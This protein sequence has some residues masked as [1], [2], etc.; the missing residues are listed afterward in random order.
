MPPIFQFQC[1][2]APEWHATAKPV[3]MSA[4]S[5]AVAITK[6]VLC[7]ICNSRMYVVGKVDGKEAVAA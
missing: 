3:E 5:S 4:P 1:P 7:G 2:K 6:L